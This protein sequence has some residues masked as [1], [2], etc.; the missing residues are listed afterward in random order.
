MADK[1]YNW[2]TLLSSLV[3]ATGTPVAMNTCNRMA[4]SIQFPDNST[5]GTIIIEHSTDAGYAGL[6][7]QI[8]S[9][10]WAAELTQLDGTF[11]GPLGF[12]RARLTLQAG[13]HTDPFTVKVQGIVG[14]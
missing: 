1:F 7:K 10:A 12:V 5:A 6:W 8:S 3:N 2:V 4:W 13:T 11:E 9:T 14:T